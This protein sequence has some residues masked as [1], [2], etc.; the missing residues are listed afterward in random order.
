MFELWVPITLAAAFLQNL[1]SALQ[2]YLKGRL[3]TAGATM[4]RFVY[5][6]PF[7]LAYVLVL[8]RQFDLPWPAVHGV[9][10]GY[11]AL[12]GVT[13]IAATALLVYLFA[14]R[15]FA[16]GTTIPRP[17]R[18]RP[19]FLALSCWATLSVGARWPGFWFRWSV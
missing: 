17:R 5:A 13:Q 1:R 8:N 16:V 12:G 19:R 11:M 18:C 6:V 7:A 9:F 4:T 14:F 3:S 10:L 15:N 2:K